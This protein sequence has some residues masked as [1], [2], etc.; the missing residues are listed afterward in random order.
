MAA[1]IR[2]RSET[3]P[4]MGPSVS[5]ASVARSGRRHAP[6]AR[7]TRTSAMMGAISTIL[8]DEPLDLLAPA[9]L[10]LGAEHGRHGGRRRKRLDPAPTE[11]D[12]HDPA[13]DEQRDGPEPD[14]PVE[15]AAR[16]HGE[17]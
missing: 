9:R 3:R 15:P 16:G 14:D 6:S 1:T 13:H 11:R 2:S 17:D 5:C 7:T 4:S 8:L 12:Q 10:V